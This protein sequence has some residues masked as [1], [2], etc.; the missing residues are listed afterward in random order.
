MKKS[1]IVEVTSNLIIVLVV[2]SM[3]LLTN[4]IYVITPA[5]G[6]GLTAIYRGNPNNKNVSFMVN[7]YWGTEYVEPILE[8]LANNEAK[9][10]FFVGGTWANS[11]SD[12][13]QKIVEAGHEVGNHGY[14][15]KDH[16]RISKERNR[17]EIYITHELVKALVNKE[18]TLFAPPSGAFNDVT[19]E[20]AE[21]L[22][23]K[24]IM[25]SKDTID[26]RD[27]DASLV[28][29]RATK[30]PQNGDLIL[31]HPT[32]HTLEAL[33][34]IIPFYKNNHFSLVTVSENIAN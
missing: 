27:K 26:W 22:N 25:W 28:Y 23:Y 31:M 20:V 1:R 33:Q 8:M 29:K 34:D 30:N 17:E 4:S 18:M 3:I 9:A 10:T 6:E 24:T 15:H 21:A 14:Y 13:L 7:V 2:L 5:S 32:A 11:N 19:L 12:V 16:T